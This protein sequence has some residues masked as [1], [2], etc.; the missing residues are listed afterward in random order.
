MMTRVLP[1]RQQD[2]FASH[3]RLCASADHWQT[4]PDRFPETNALQS[5]DTAAHQTMS[6]LESA[7]SLLPW[8]PIPF[9][10]SPKGLHASF[11]THRAVAPIR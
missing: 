8:T 9:A 1:C 6:W 4:D 7:F 5:S 2:L 3:R 10:P 11:K